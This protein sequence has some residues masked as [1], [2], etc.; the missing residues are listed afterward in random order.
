MTVAHLCECGCGE[1]VRMS[2]RTNARRGLVKGEPLRYVSGHNRRKHLTP[3]DLSMTLG[4]TERGSYG[5]IVSVCRLDE[6][7]E[8]VLHRTGMTTMN[9]LRAIV[10]DLDEADGDWRIVC[11]S[12]PVTVYRDMQA[13]RP[14]GQ[15][16]L[17]PETMYLAKLRRTDLL[18]PPSHEPPLYDGAHYTKPPHAGTR[19]PVER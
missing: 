17:P 19:R 14:T 4:G 3:R 8:G 1:P 2:D 9:A 5:A 11:I 6:P 12:T 13:A 10:A 16:S 15:G 18:A 7:G